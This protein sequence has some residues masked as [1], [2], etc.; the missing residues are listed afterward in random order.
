VASNALQFLFPSWFQLDPRFRNLAGGGTF[1]GL[2]GVVYAVFG[3]LLA[4]TSYDREPGL[5]IPNDTIV[6]LLIW[7]VACMTGWLG[8]IA[9]TAH[10]AG[11]LCG[12]V[13]GA[14]PKTWRT[15]RAGQ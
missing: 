13:I 12:F 2:S 1:G 3:Y 4:K 5:R 15:I 8:A 11:F 6:L 7:L 9:N 10:V 14:V